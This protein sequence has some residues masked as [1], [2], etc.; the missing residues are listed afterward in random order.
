MQMRALAPDQ[1][2]TNGRFHTLDAHNTV[3]QAVAVK[4]G[5][6]LTVGHTHEIAM[7]K[8]VRKTIRRFWA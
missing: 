3:A 8:S 7:T 4:N 5:R 6:F 2:W 1:I